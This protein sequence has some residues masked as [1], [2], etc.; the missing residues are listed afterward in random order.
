MK[1]VKKEVYG[2]RN[3]WLKPMLESNNINFFSDLWVATCR[4]K[5]N[6]DNLS[7]YAVL[8]ESKSDKNV[9]ENIKENVPVYFIRILKNNQVYLEN[10][11]N[12]KSKTLSYKEFIRGFTSKLGC[13]HISSFA[14]GSTNASSLS[15]FFREY[16]GK[17]FALTDVDFYFG[18]SNIMIEEKGFVKGGEYCYLGIGQCI[19][20]REIIKDIFNNPKFYLV[21]KQEKK[22]YMSELI[23]LNCFNSEEIKGWG[24]MNPIKVY[25]TSRKGIINKLLSHNN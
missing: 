6:N 15:V 21:S 18:A 14:K 17:G 5:I 13:K 16:M 22:F 7:R 3:S 10:L 8:L 9:K 24:K 1:E 25:E 2:T 11:R 19:S 4:S 20:F 12:N 23:K